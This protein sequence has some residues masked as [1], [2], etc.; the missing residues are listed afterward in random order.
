MALRIVSD[1]LFS[2]LMEHVSGSRFETFAKQV[3]AIHFGEIFVPLG[4][5]HD[6][7]GRRGPLQL[8]PRGK[9]EAFDVCAVFGDKRK[10]REDQDHGHN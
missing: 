3:F 2:Y 1:D 4:G 5:I 10:R 8:R 6:G 9:G 7:W